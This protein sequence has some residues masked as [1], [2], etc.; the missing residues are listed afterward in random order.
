MHHLMEAKDNMSKDIQVDYAQLQE[1]SKE[2][3]ERSEQVASLLS[4]MNDAYQDVKSSWEGGDARQFEQ[5]ME[6]TI[7]VAIKALQDALTITEQTNKTIIKD[8]ENAEDEC[9]QLLANIHVA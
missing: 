9:R 8:F 3:G 1:I 7:L 4:M 2:F 6:S 5:L